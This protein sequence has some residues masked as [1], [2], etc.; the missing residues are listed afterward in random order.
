MQKN[1]KSRISITIFPAVNEMLEKLSKR[2]N[3]SKSVLVEKA[4]KDFLKKQLE[5]DA[6]KL[7]KLKFSDLPSEDDW[8]QIQ[9]NI[10]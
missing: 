4:V 10:D 5:K 6:K 7:A 2:E 3:V 1:I 8:M 9:S